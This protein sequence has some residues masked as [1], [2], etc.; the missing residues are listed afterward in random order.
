MSARIWGGTVT[1]RLS[2]DFGVLMKYS[3]SPVGP[4]EADQFHVRERRTAAASPR[5]SSLSG[6]LR[7]A[8]N[9]AAVKG[10]HFQ[11][12]EAGVC[13]SR[14]LHRQARCDPEHIFY[15]RDGKFP[16]LERVSHQGAASWLCIV[17]NQHAST[18][19]RPRR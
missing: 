15:L 10:Q 19:R 7:S 13:L 8:V 6:G 17:G 2:R 11:L 1:L 3:L 14:T 12:S 5:S 4:T 9:A 16:P 18:R